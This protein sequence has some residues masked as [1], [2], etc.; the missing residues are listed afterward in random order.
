MSAAHSDKIIFIFW[1]YED[2]SKENTTTIICDILSP[3]QGNFVTEI[4]Q[5]S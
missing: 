3:S 5:I 2:H 1:E 4:K